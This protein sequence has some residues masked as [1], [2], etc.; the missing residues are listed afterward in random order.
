MIVGT[1]VGIEI[2]AQVVMYLE[3]LGQV[4]PVVRWVYVGT[5]RPDLSYGFL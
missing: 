2:G 4:G 3:R 1:V 5:A